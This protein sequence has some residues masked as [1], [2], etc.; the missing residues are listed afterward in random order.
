M[1]STSLKTTIRK[2]ALQNRQCVLDAAIALFNTQGLDVPL[3]QIAKRANVGV[4]TVY[5]HFP[6]KH[7]L[8]EAVVWQSLQL[9]I[10]TADELSLR[11]DSGG[12]VQEF[13]LFMVQN[14]KFKRSIINALT[15]AGQDVAS[16]LKDVVEEFEAKFDLLLTAAKKDGL[17]RPDITSADIRALLAGCIWAED[18]ASGSTDVAKLINIIFEGMKA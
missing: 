2:D 9:L 17:M 11:E 16:N 18:N 7:A 1:E 4:G 12:A 5:R 13:M 3:E 15:A 14:A 8:F 10:D 6:N